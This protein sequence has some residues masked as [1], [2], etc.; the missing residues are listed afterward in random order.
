MC[1]SCRG[2][3]NSPIPLLSL[4][5]VVAAL[6][7]HRLTRRGVEDWTWPRG[8]PARPLTVLAAVL[9][10]AEVL[11]VVR[12]RVGAAARAV[13]AL[14]GRRRRAAHV[15]QGHRLGTQRA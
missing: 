11:L 8:G 6:S 14:L 9:V 10:A 2:A 15:A 5:L 12:V 7:P 1:M 13:A 4:I 3:Y